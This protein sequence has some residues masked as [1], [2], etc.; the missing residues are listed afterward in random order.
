MVYPVWIITDPCLG[1]HRS[2]WRFAKFYT[3]LKKAFVRLRLPK[4]SEKTGANELRAKP[5]KTIFQM[6][7][8][9]IVD[10]M[11][12]I[13]MGAAAFSAVLREWTEAVVIF[14]IV[15]VNAGIGMVQEKKPS[16]RWRRCAI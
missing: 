9:Q 14:A 15:F 7:K 8:A 4:G 2:L 11:V 12:L 1:T 16:G 3:P 10:P 6:L 5:P 13:L